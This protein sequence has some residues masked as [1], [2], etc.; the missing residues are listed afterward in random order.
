M[1]F[2]GFLDETNDFFLGVACSNAAGKVRHIRSV[3]RVALFNY[4]RIAHINIS[5]FQSGLFQ[6]RI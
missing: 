3:A 6:N 5:L 4:N 2:N 1:K